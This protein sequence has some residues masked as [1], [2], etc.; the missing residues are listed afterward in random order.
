[1]N[2][3]IKSLDQPIKTPGSG[4][5]RELA[6]LAKLYS[7]DAKYSGEN[8]NF[9]FKLTMFN[10]MC[11]RADVPPE[12]KLKAFLTMLKGL[13]LN[14]YYS[15]STSKDHPIT[16]D[17][18]CASMM[19]YFEGVEYKRSILNKWNNITLKTVMSSNEGK[20][21][22]ECLHLLI[23]QLR[24]LQ[25]GLGPALRTDDFIHNKL[26]N[27]CQ[28]VPACQY[29]CFK[30]SETL[31]ELIN[32]LKSSI[33]TYEKAH[34]TDIFFTDR[35]YHRNFQPRINQD[36]GNRGYQDRKYQDRRNQ[37]RTEKKCFVCQKEG[38]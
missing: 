14:Y 6:N 24:H 29:A 8:D 9:S 22:D 12:V 17:D 36:R 32:D 21:M 30:P 7:D 26:I 4:Y 2:Q 19:N 3:P 16:F 15:N 11:D 27:A 5:G 34:P 10:E 23:K 37:G 13:A 35:R 31:A 38:C 33:V 20:S 18:V 28:E 25:H 1:M